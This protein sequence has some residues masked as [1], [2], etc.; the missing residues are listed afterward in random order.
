VKSGVNISARFSVRDFFLL[1]AMM[2]CGG[3]LY[4]CYQHDQQ[5]K[6]LKQKTTLEEKQHEQHSN[7][8][9]ASAKY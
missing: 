5:I 7:S 1:L 6:E 2:G 9:S 8:S 3:N 4:W